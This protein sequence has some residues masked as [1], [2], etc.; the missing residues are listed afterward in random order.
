MS[1]V[2]VLY[3]YE[4]H[5]AT[6]RLAGL[7]D[8]SVVVSVPGKNKKNKIVF[9][10][11]VGGSAFV[12]DPFPT[13]NLF[14]AGAYG[15]FAVVQQA[16]PRKPQTTFLLSKDGDVV[17]FESGSTTRVK[18]NVFASRVDEAGVYGEIRSGNSVSFAQWD[19]SGKLVISS[20]VNYI[21]GTLNNVPVL[22]NLLVDLPSNL[23]E[24]AALC[25]QNGWVVGRAFEKDETGV[26][27]TTTANSVSWLWSMS[28][29]LKL[30]V[31]P[32]G[33]KLSVTTV[34]P[35][36]KFVVGLAW[37][38]N[39]PA[40]ESVLVDLTKSTFKSL[41]SLA[42]CSEGG[43]ADWSGARFD[44]DGTLYLRRIKVLNGP[45]EVVK[46]SGIK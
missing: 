41:E 27:R 40:Q 33:R 29:G 38:N 22:R 12:L 44:N 31:M 35:D 7:T 46:I 18:N 26:A 4:K 13:S 14:P 37:N 9:V 36:G 39:S 5:D 11:K 8:D 20:S 19:F 6:T 32:D 25:V 16:A 34:S 3:S 1:N 15:D 2:T 17:Q 45:M 30:C 24:S 10:P 23:D 21:A 28:S 43:M 42:E